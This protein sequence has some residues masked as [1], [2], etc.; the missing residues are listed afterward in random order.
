MPTPLKANEA[1]SEE[2]PVWSSQAQA[3]PLSES[4]VVV[5]GLPRAG[6]S[7]LMQMLASGGIPVLTDDVR[8]AD[9]DNPRGYYEFEPVKKLMSDSRWLRDAKGK[10]VKIVAPL[11]PSIPR[12]IPLRLI[13]IERDLDEILASQEKM[14]ER[15][16][17][18]ISGTVERRER[19]KAEYRRTLR[20]VAKWIGNRADASVLALERSAILQDATGASERIREFLEGG[21]NVSA[22]AAAVDP[23]LHRNRQGVRATKEGGPEAC[24]HGGNGY[25]V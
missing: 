21:V 17:E 6:T 3:A 13:V 11:V 22:M 14:I 18:K 8:I 23:S 12:G 10:A 15:R 24:P 25:A 9:E 1:V 19:L 2:S 4:L 7:M 20:R 16:G 5:T